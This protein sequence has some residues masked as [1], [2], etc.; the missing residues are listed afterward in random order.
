AVMAEFI[1]LQDP[2]A[3]TIEYLGFFVPKTA[4]QFL[5]VTANCA[6]NDILLSVSDDGGDGELRIV[7]DA[8]QFMVEVWHP[9]SVTASS[10]CRDLHG[11]IRSWRDRDESKTVTF[12]RTTQ[13]PTFMPDEATRTPGYFTIVDLSFRADRR[14]IKKISGS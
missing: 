14:E 12:L 10:W 6:R 9:D 4:G 13:R 1:R 3:R 8:A 5:Q 2:V 11:L 7:L